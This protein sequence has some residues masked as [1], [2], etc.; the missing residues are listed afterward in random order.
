[1]IER[2]EWLERRVAMLEAALA[3]AEARAAA[4][5]QALWQYGGAL[6]LTVGG[7]LRVRAAKTT[8]SIGAGSGNPAPS[9]LSWG[10][11]PI[12]FYDDVS[13]VLG[14]ETATARNAGGSIASGRVV[15]VAGRDGGPWEI[16]VDFC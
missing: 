3:A 7:H 15:I 10:T 16:L 8:G 14:S 6:S 4:A 9:T 5:E 12:T 2:L 13:G 1:M 11:G